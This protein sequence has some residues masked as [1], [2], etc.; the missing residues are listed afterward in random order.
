[1]NMGIDAF[2]LLSFMGSIA[3][4]VSLAE[5]VAKEKKDELPSIDASKMASDLEGI[6]DAVDNY[7][8]TKYDKPVI[9]NKERDDVKDRFFS[10]N[11]NLI[12]MKEDVSRLIDSYLNQ[13]EIL[14]EK[15]MS[16]GEC[17]IKKQI[18]DLGSDINSQLTFQ[19]KALD[20]I[21][22]ESK[23]AV[24]KIEELYKRGDKSAFLKAY[25]D[26]KQHEFEDAPSGP[27]VVGNWSID[28]AYIDVEVD[29]K[30][31]K[32]TYARASE[33][34]IKWCREYECGAH[35]IYGQ[36]GHGK[37][38]LGLKLVHDYIV[39]NV[40]FKVFSFPL[41]SPCYQMITGE[42]INIYDVLRLD[43]YNDESKLDDKLIENSL[44]ILD[45]YD[46]LQ[47]TLPQ[48]SQFA[49]PV[50]FFS[51]IN[52]FAIEK[53]AYILITTRTITVDG[54]TKNRK[55]EL[56]KI[57]DLISMKCLS[58]E[59][60]NDWIN[61][62]NP[63]YIEKFSNLRETYSKIKE[64]QNTEEVDIFGIPFIFLMT[65][66]AEFDDKADNLVQLYDKLLEATLKRRKP[67]I[68]EE[69]II[70]ER[71]KYEDIALKMMANYGKY[72]VIPGRNKQDYSLYTYSY[73]M[74]AYSGYA[75]CNSDEINRFIEFYH[76][77][78]YE[79]FLAYS[80]YNRFNEATE[81]NVDEF[82]CE[83]EKGYPSSEVIR[84]IR[85][86]IGD[87]GGCT[88]ND[89]VRK[90]IENT[91]ALIIRDGE[92]PLTRCNRIFVNALNLMNLFANGLSIH[93]DIAPN[94]SSYKDTKL[95]QLLRQFKCTQVDFSG[96]KMMGAH[97]D[98]TD[99]RKADFTN[100]SMQN[101]DM[102]RTMFDSSLFV[103]T[104]MSYGRFE[105]GSFTKAIFNRVDMR[106]ANFKRGNFTDA[107]FTDVIID[108]GTQFDNA[109]FDR[110]TTNVD[111][112]SRIPEFFDLVKEGKIH[113]VNDKKAD[114]DNNTE[115]DSGIN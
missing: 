19:K 103:S 24:E 74:K 115:V 66:A 105:D 95:C 9:S 7:L 101:S 25:Y 52:T 5:S 83:L 73:Y 82:L 59:D 98:R 33:Y 70:A 39:G 35:L 50:V 93:E 107:T 16:L 11:K 42:R 34:I 102:F 78:F 41:V 43:K 57:G 4:I 58:P 96:S 75:D 76:R 111:L 81:E 21:Q 112:S 72:A 51:F 92:N 80:L 63:N 28:K 2:G 55:K 110:L 48:D 36:P 113:Y 85:Q 6:A 23:I 65:V 29:K 87:N 79:Y 22:K 44:I 60:Q 3:S 32:N 61:A 67:N 91:D 114:S 88:Y 54:L 109:T 69:E 26:Q 13:L 12:F 8:A 62:H 77:T 53:K 20:V 106:G 10:E 104:N 45:G 90:R 27:T 100:A 14:L 47:A 86:I 1:M 15:R 38:T 84:Y 30:T 31:Q 46:E 68:R 89:E 18:D 49:D 97:I 17:V 99:L 64:S 37:T 40:D 108:D 56:R 94:Y 71:K